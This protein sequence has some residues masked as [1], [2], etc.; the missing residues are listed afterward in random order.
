MNP[1][2][3]DPLSVL[4]LR[5]DAGEQDIRA[6]YLELVK[7]HTP[8]SDPEKFREIRDAYE[9]ANDPVQIAH[10]LT[11]P[12]DD[13]APDWSAAIASQRDKPPRLTTD[14]ILSLGN[15]DEAS[16]SGQGGS[17]GYE[18]GDKKYFIEDAHE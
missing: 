6:R 18:L 4:G 3:V 14:F 17:D 2:E 16:A 13:D 11:I 15:R 1:T 12:P 7:R 10:R 9:V 5:Q 8:E